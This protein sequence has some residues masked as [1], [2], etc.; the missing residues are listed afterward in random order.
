MKPGV[1]VGLGIVLVLAAVMALGAA[2][3]FSY[4]ANPAG[5][6]ELRLTWRTR[7]PLVDECRRL[8]QEEQE[9]LPV[10][11]RREEVC[12]GRVASY[13][14]DVWVDGE[15]RHSSTI[16]GA[17]AR[18]DRP[19]YVYDRLRLDPGHHDVHVVFERIGGADPP[20]AGAAEETTE[21]AE[22]SGSAPERLELREGIELAAREVALI[23]YDA[24]ARRLVLKT[25]PGR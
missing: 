6:A 7:A 4:M 25:A 11:M 19:L 9:A 23:T 24:V 2:T 20:A 5:E 3:R 16:H 1:R 10:H 18:G 8:T 17:G 21:A 15:V 13:S 14:L 22:R 12:E